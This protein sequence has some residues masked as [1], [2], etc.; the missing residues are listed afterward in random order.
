MKR[1]IKYISL[2]LLLMLPILNSCKKETS[3]ENCRSLNGT[4]KPPTANAGLDQVI[5][6]PTDS[7]LLD[8][9]TSSDPD[10]IISEWLWTK[11]SGPASFNIIKSTDSL[12]KVK[13][14]VSGTYLFELK[15]TDNNGL[16]AKDTMQVFVNAMMMTSSCDNRP[17]INATLVPIGTLSSARTKIMSASAGNKILFIG[18]MHSGQNWWNEPVPVDIYDFSNNTWSLH[19][20]VPDNPQ[21]SHF[22]VGAAIASVGNKILFAGG[23]DGFG[24]NQSSRVDIYDAS[25]D[26]WTVESLSVERQGLVAATIGDKVLFAGGF[27]YPVG[28]NWGEFNIVDIYNNS[29]DSWSIATLSQAR[30]DIAATSAGNKVYFAGGRNGMNVSKTIDIYDAATNSWSVSSLQQPRTDMANIAD[31]SKIFW[32]GGANNFNGAEWTSNNS[33]EI[34]DLNTGV[35]SSVC[36][37]P[38]F[39]FSAV[40]KNEQ[41]VFFTG[42][43][44]SGVEFEI[45]D[46]VTGIWSTGKLNQKIQGAA[47]ISVNNTIYVTGGIYSNQVWKLEF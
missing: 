34:L 35:T 47:I 25:S 39:G 36:I 13:A 2:I 15:V 21:L 9:R 8:G 10:G 29:N 38:R 24:D 26:T 40:K 1:E 23:G 30:M 22:R 28:N 44:G 32:A 46:T 31:N 43:D 42:Y 14:L 12:T 41:I 37:H 17:I 27:G 33:V 18:G 20:L 19:L 16:S 45:Y 6:L 11:I 4:N 7:V 3:C 5:T